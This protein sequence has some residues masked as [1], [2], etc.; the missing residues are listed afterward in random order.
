MAE[1]TDLATRTRTESE[2]DQRSAQEIR[3]D[4]AAKRETISE[5]VDKLGDR[6]Q[7]T[8]DWREYVSEYPFV[9]L[10]AAAGLGFI[11]A[12]MFRPKPSPRDRIMDA[13]AESLEDV[14]DR[15]R[16]NFD[17][18]IPKRGMAAGTGNTIKAAVT[19]MVTRAA[20]NYA[21][22]KLGGV[23]PRQA[24]TRSGWGSIDEPDARSSNTQAYSSSNIGS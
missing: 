20:V 3:Q 9:A 6:I 4:I 8:L 7:Q 13:L 22:N 16:S 24:E 17:G 10:G 19:A 5:T 1:R 23:S 14:T 2:A 18:V 11:L 12:S 21:K 15:V